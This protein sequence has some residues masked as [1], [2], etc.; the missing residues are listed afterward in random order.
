MTNNE[1]DIMFS[2]LQLPSLFYRRTVSE[3]L[4]GHSSD[5]VVDLFTTGM[6]HFSDPST[7]RLFYLNYLDSERT[8]ADESG[9][10]LTL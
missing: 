5:L 8:V 9:I 6:I 4:V 10:M 1:F 3:S 2:T 7:S